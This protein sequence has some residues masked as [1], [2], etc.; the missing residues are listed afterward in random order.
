MGEHIDRCWA[1]IDLKALKHNYNIVRQSVA[2]NTRIMA[3]VKANAYGHGAPE[4]AG[5]LEKLGADSFA[6]ATLDEAKELRDAGIS[7]PILVLGYVFPDRLSEA[8]MINATISVTSL[9]HA[10]L[11][12]DEAQKFGYK[13]RVNIKI[14]TGMSRLGIRVTDDGSAFEDVIGVTSLPNLDITGIYTHFSSADSAT[15]DS[16]EFTKHQAELFRTLVTKLQNVGV[17]FDRIH[18]NNSAGIIAYPDS[19]FN[20][21]R[22]GICLYGVDPL[23]PSNPLGF[24]PVM[25]LKTTVISLRKISK[26]DYVGYNRTFRAYRD[27]TVATLSIGYADGVA[28]K[29]SNSFYVKSPNG[30]LDII[31]NIC[32][33]QM[34]VDATDDPTLQIGDTITLFGGDSPID[35]VNISG[36]IGTIPYEVMCNISLRVPRY[37]K[38]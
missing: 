25:S 11:I 30:L 35:I 19:Q 22:A 12:S 33:D 2:E 26:G 21:V 10:K 8:V 34:M 32:M 20:T 23:N 6:V 31:G 28:R 24:R 37:Y 13:P 17:H 29:L 14:D 4:V 27:T 7:R 38:N 1:E 3:V 18:C 9:D 16:V 15:E 36:I 5:A